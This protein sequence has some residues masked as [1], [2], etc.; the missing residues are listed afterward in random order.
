MIQPERHDR[1]LPVGTGVVKRTIGTHVRYPVIMPDLAVHKV[2]QLRWSIAML[3]SQSLA[4]LDREQAFPD[5][6]LAGAVFGQVITSTLESH[7][8]K[9]GMLFV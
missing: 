2:E 3:A 6:G 8:R 5:A 9:R 1:L 4:A 7:R